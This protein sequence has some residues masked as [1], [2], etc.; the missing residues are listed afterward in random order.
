MQW[1]FFLL[2]WFFSFTIYVSKHIGCARESRLVYWLHFKVNRDLYCL[3]SVGLLNCCSM[4]IE[5]S[6]SVREKTRLEARKVSLYVMKC[7][8]QSLFIY[9]LF[10]LIPSCILTS[11]SAASTLLFSYLSFI[12]SKVGFG[13]LLLYILEMHG[14]RFMYLFPLFQDL[15]DL[16][17]CHISLSLLSPTSSAGTWAPTWR[18][19]PKCWCV[20]RLWTRWPVAGSYQTAHQRRVCPWC[21]C[22]PCGHL[23]WLCAQEQHSGGCS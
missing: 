17:L 22:G 15:S 14:R 2:L 3:L 13:V 8:P 19:G 21:Q 20:S 6:L 16:C 12:P 9:M 5:F 18:P 11:P 1:G 23:L 4:V 7:P 10:I